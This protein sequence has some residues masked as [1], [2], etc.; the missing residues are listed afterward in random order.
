[1]RILWSVLILLTMSTAVAAQQAGVADDTLYVSGRA[2]VFFGPSQAE[3]LAMTHGD[4][5][6]IDHD[7]YY[8]YHFRNKVLPFLKSN[9]IEEFST[10]RPDIQVQFAGNE[11]IHYVRSDFE[12]AVGLIMTDGLHEPTVFLGFATESELI[13]MFEAYF[14]L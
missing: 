6:A 9:K 1:M 8:F 13:S 10:V 12:R 5:D 4:K 2:V 11:R 7:L 3:Y 14:D